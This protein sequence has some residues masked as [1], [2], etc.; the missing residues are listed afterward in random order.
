MSVNMII[1][2]AAGFDGTTAFDLG[3]PASVV[4]GIISYS[5]AAPIGTI[6]LRTLPHRFAG[7]EGVDI[8]AEWYLQYISLTLGI[9]TD[10]GVINVADP[11]ALGTP[12]VG[13]GFNAV[14]LPAPPGSRDAPITEWNIPIPQ[15]ALITALSAPFGGGPPVA[16][17]LA[18]SMWPIGSNDWA[19]LE[20]CHLW[21]PARVV[22]S[23]FIPPS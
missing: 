21:S 13:A 14:F 6:D 20:C 15:G 23:A 4:N 12:V 19:D 10:T 2:T 7:G 5:T 3:N 11:D 22:R 1:S 17:A 18:L 9:G 8:G 16:G